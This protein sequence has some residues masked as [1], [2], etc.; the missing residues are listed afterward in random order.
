MT[1]V[2]C[3]F[4]FFPF[5]ISKIARNHTDGSITH[6]YKEVNHSPLQ[7]IYKVQRSGVVTL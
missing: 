7:R 1:N 2:A 3:F 6:I 5:K 4:V